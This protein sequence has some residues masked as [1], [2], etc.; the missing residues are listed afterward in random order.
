[1]DL[2]PDVTVGCEVCQGQRFQPHILE[3]RWRGKSITEVLEASVSEALQLFGQDRALAQPLQALW[4]IGLGYLRLGQEGRALST[5]ELQRLR[6]AGLGV[7]KPR[8]ILLD[9]PSR[10]L[11][12]EDVDRLLGV[13]RALA[14]TGQLVVVVEHDLDFIAG[15]DWVIDLGPEGGPGGGRLVAQGSPAALAGIAESHTG[16]ALAP[17]V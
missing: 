16:R 2:L 17:R 5:G 13:L 4:D 15:A 9:E 12:F 7:G 8:A 11:G 6:L 14:R 3:C 10:G 1:M